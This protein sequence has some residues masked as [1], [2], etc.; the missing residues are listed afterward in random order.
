MRATFVSIL[1]SLILLGAVVVTAGAEP[2]E[3]SAGDK[4]HSRS[5]PRIAAAAVGRAASAPIKASAEAKPAPT[6]AIRYVMRFNIDPETGGIGVPSL[7]PPVEDDVLQ[8]VLPD[9]AVMTAVEENGQETVALQ[10]ARAAG[11][12][13]FTPA[14]R[15]TRR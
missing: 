7:L 3:R 2:R 11:Q 10:I 12:D 8:V 1:T 15:R 4:S 6:A 5:S 14:G 13:R 9:G